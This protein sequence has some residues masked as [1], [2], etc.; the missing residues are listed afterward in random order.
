MESSINEN[1]D[2]IVMLVRLAGPPN[3]APVANVD[4]N[5]GGD[6]EAMENFMVAE[7]F[8][9]GVGSLT[10]EDNNSGELKCHHGKVKNEL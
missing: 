6:D 4:R 10:D 7:E 1:H 9:G 5:A 3:D 8:G 2:L